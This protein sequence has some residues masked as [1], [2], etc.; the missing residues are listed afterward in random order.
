MRAIEY[1]AIA[2]E[3]DH[4]S[5][6]ES[7]AL[8]RRSARLLNKLLTSRR[9]SRYQARSSDHRVAGVLESSNAFFPRQGSGSVASN[10]TGS[11]TVR[12]GT[13]CGRVHA[14]PRA[15]PA[16]FNGPRLAPARRTGPSRF[17]SPG[18]SSTTSSA[19][20]PGDAPIV[21]PDQDAERCHCPS[22]ILPFTPLRMSFPR[23]RPSIS[24][25]IGG[26]GRLVC[27]SRD[28][29]FAVLSRR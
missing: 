22:G 6:R 14:W 18:G 9:Y 7:Y 2:V 23:R 28:T 17:R 3:P 19:C 25:P 1:R 4:P 13:P 12:C 24:S 29:K 10:R 11:A 20:R 16:P 26:Q 21:K 15:G 5:A 27:R 8:P